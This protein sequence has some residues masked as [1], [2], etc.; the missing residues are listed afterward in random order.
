MRKIFFF[1][2][3]FFC[4][5]LSQVCADVIVLKDGGTIKGKILKETSV[6]VRIKPSG[7]SIAFREYLKDEIK[8]IVVGNALETKKFLDQSGMENTDQFKELKDVVQ[9]LSSKPKKKITKP[10]KA[11]QPDVITN[12][13]I[14]QY[15][16]IPS[17]EASSAGGLPAFE[18]KP[19][20]MEEAME[21]MNQMMQAEERRQGGS[22]S[23]NKMSSESAAQIEAEMMKMMSVGV[24]EQL[25]GMIWF[26]VKTIGVAFLIFSVIAYFINRK[27]DIDYAE[28]KKKGGFFR[29]VMATVIDNSILHWGFG[30]VAIIP[31]LFIP[32]DSISWVVI[33]LFIVIYLIFLVWYQLF[34]Y[35]TW[36][37]TYGRY[38]MGIK[39]VDA[40][41]QQRPGYG[42]AFKRGFV[43]FFLWFVEAPIVLFSHSKRRIGDAWANT[44]VIVGDHQKKWFKRI[45]PGILILAFVLFTDIILEPYAYNK[46]AITQVARDLLVKNRPDLSLEAFPSDVTMGGNQMVVTFPLENE[47]GRYVSIL[48]TRVPRGWK[49]RGLKFIQKKYFGLWTI[50]SQQ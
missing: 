1:I 38:V 34:G 19:K 4:L 41:S 2:I 3:L 24:K 6:Y 7:S 25:P 39:V 37:N 27:I 23:P 33:L 35:I 16:G 9:V 26:F 46:M 18:G 49:A 11:S 36:P 42:Q 21:R 5:G 13:T 20:N 32:F 28:G 45:L 47:K 29:R 10:K 14:N 44:V 43:F 30:S 48:L 50:T 12:E 22:Y 40:E 8:E 31:G 15:L 17:D